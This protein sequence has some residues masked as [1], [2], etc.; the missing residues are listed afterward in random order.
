MLVEVI[1]EGCVSFR[2]QE[3]RAFLGGFGVTGSVI[4]CCVAT[5]P[6]LG[7]LKHKE[8]TF[9]VVCGHW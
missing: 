9:S 8:V 6:N 2:R 4:Y 1:I 3:G 7:G 5:S